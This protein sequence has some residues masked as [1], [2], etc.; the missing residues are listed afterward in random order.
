MRTIRC[1]PGEEDPA[2]AV[3]ILK[4]FPVLRKIAR[5]FSFGSGNASESTKY[6][7]RLFSV[8]FLPT[9]KAKFL[10]NR[11][12]RYAVGIERLIGEPS[13]DGAVDHQLD[14]VALDYT[15]GIQRRH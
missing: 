11:K 4:P 6:H 9:L 14:F 5:L 13:F 8:C 1:W 15:A 7:M 12:V 2:G 10:G 3:L